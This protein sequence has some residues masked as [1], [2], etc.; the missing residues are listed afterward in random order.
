MHGDIECAGNA[1]QLCLAEHLDLKQF[2]ASLSCMNFGSFPGAIGTVALTRKCAETN[3]V[4]WWQSGVG[5]CIQGQR[6]EREGR[7]ARRLASREWNVQE[8]YPAVFDVDDE[9]AELEYLAHE[10]R[11]LLRQSVRRTHKAEVTKSCTIDIASTIKHD[12]RRRCIVDGG[13]WKGCDDGHAPADFVR[14]I[15]KEWKALNDLEIDLV[16]TNANKAPPARDEDDGSVKH[17]EIEY[18]LLEV[19]GDY[20]EN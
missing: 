4:D 13:V 11:R 2:Y 17:E 15:E 8:A 1:H 10:A 18:D 7:A 12:R 14:V 5:R 20:S 19:L 6:A 16:D 9:D 3:G